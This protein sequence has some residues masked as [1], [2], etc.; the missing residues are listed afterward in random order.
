MAPEAREEFLRAKTADADLRAEVLSLLGVTMPTGDILERPAMEWYHPEIASTEPVD[1][2][3]RLMVGELI[4]GRFAVEAFLGRGGMG[5]VYAA[6][7]RELHERVA[8]KLL[9]PQ[10]AN[11]PGFLD[12]FRR[13]IRLAR[14]IA[15]PNVARVFDLI[16]EPGHRH[17][18]LYFYVL[19][20]LVGETLGARL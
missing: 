3:P 8:L 4:A 5:E 2:E 11:Q 7:D 18:D 16:Q 20:L 15:H 19:A 13:E 17:G 12:R 1:T 14:R 9:H 10:L 6:E